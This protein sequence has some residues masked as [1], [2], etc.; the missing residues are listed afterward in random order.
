MIVDWRLLVDDFL[1][2]IINRQCNYSRSGPG[3]Q[4]WALFSLTNEAAADSLKTWL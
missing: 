1:F 2:S 4:K 3:L